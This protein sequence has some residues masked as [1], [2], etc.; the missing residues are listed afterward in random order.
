MRLLLCCAVATLLPEDR[1][2]QVPKTCPAIAAGTDPSWGWKGKG[3]GRRTLH[4]SHF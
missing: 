4:A 1:S 2:L 3:K